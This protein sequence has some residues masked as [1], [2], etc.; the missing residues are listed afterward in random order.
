M[1]Y[2]TQGKIVKLKRNE[3]LINILSILLAVSIP[4]ELGPNTGMW[5][6]LLLALYWAVYVTHKKQSSTEAYSSKHEEESIA[7]T[8][9]VPEE[10][11]GL[12][13]TRHFW[14]CIVVIQAVAIDKQASRSTACKRPDKSREMRNYHQQIF[15]FLERNS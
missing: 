6:D 5:S 11:W 14:P 15:L 1:W 12:H 10:K 8:S 4:V 7:Y 2:L 9:H 13:E 3:T